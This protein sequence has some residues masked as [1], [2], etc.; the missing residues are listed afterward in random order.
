MKNL[1]GDPSL[2]PG[3]SAKDIE[4]SFGIRAFCEAC[5]FPCPQHETLCRHCQTREDNK[6]ELS[7]SDLRD[8]LP[9]Y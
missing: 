6:D 2:P 5:G 3:C 4:R 7:S 1:P 8:L 9:E